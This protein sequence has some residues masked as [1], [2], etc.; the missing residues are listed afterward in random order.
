MQSIQKAATLKRQT[1]TYIE[2]DASGLD[3]KPW[4]LI[5]IP[6][7][8]EVGQWYITSIWTT[9]KAQLHALAIVW[10]VAPQVVLVN[11]PGTCIPVCF[12][13]LVFRCVGVTDMTN[14]GLVKNVCFPPI[15]GPGIYY[16]HC[17][18]YFRLFATK[19]CKIIYV[20]SIA[21]TRKLSL[22]GKILY[23]TRI[24]D[25]MLVQWKE[26]ADKFPGTKF[27]GRLY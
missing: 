21:R 11:G 7:S 16:F 20:E 10:H 17:L 3:A 25:L 26:L 4:E 15:G 19:P 27:A 5:E 14:A 8:R 18:M 6:R 2:A 1:H 22:S 13:A 12:A 23:Y 9:L 24:A